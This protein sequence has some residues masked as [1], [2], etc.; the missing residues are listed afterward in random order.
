VPTC[1]YEQYVNVWCLLS[2]F[3]CLGRVWISLTGRLLARPAGETRL[4]SVLHACWS[5]PE[6]ARFGDAQLGGDMEW[7]W[8]IP[9]H[10]GSL[11]HL[12]AFYHI[13]RK[14]QA[15]AQNVPQG[16]TGHVETKPELPTQKP[17]RRTMSK[18][19]STVSVCVCRC[20]IATVVLVVTQDMYLLRVRQ[21]D[22][23]DRFRLLQLLPVLLRQFWSSMLLSVTLRALPSDIQTLPDFTKVRCQINSRR[24]RLTRDKMTKTMLS[25]RE[26]LSRQKHSTD[27]GRHESRSKG[28]YVGNKQRH[29][30]CVHMCYAM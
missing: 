15:V 2:A 14:F 11:S 13:S 6:R 1:A 23:A 22:S 12:I 3:R 5:W 20:L 18:Q 7:S 17:Y 24:R 29:A 16:S 8:V 28:K 19:N 30:V 4:H 25:F 27:F 10:F 26:K 9:K 21:V